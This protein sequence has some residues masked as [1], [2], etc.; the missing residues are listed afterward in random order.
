MSKPRV[1]I[2]KVNGP[3]A[4]KAGVVF[5]AVS[6]KFVAASLSQLFHDAEPGA[7]R[8]TECTA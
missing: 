3:P 4:L 5:T 2:D 8:D 7:L 1:R 6:G